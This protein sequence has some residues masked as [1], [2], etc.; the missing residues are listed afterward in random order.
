LLVC[1]WVQLHPTIRG[2][3][4]MDQA[5]LP[6]QKEK[7]CY[8]GARAK[9]TTDRVSGARRKAGHIPDL[10]IVI[11]HI[12]K[13]PIVARG[14]EPW[15]SLLARAAQMPNVFAKLSGRDSGNAGQWS[16]ADIDPYLDHALRLFGSDRLM[17]GSD[18]PVAILRGGYAKVWRETNAALSRLSSRERDKILGGTACDVYHLPVRE[19]D[20]ARGS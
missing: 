11:D 5:A 3:N 16:A 4:D 10:R 2:L 13:P 15:G 6:P 8:L 19:P 12:G 17:F 18:W 20:L 1:S 7:V 14:W 9:Q